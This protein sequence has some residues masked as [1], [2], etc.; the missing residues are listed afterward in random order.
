VGWSYRKSVRMGPLRVNFSRSGASV[1]TGIKGARVR[2]GPRGTYVTFSA[3]GFRYSRKLAHSELP[4]SLPDGTVDDLGSR[5]ATASVS[6]LQSISAEEN[7][8]ELQS[9]I[10]SGG[11]AA[12]WGCFSVFAV[13]MVM[14]FVSSD[15]LVL[16]TLIAVSFLGLWVAQ[17]QDEANAPYLFYDVDDSVVVERFARVSAAGEA[18]KTSQHLWHI[19]ASQ[20]TDDRK[21]NAGASHLIRRTPISCT[22]GTLGQLRMNIE[23]WSVPVGPQRLLFLPDRLLILEGKQLAGVP[24]ESL[25]L[26]CFPKNFIEEE[27]VPQDSR[28]VGTTWKYVNKNGS[29][30]RRFNNN[31]QLPIMEYGQLEIRTTSGIH[32]VLQ[33]SSLASAQKTA[34]ALASLQDFLR[35]ESSQPA[36]SPEQSEPQVEPLVA[37]LKYVALADR[38]FSSEE[39]ELIHE[40]LGRKYALSREAIDRMLDNPKVTYSSLHEA[41]LRQQPS[42]ARGEILQMLER[43]CAADGKV[44]P[45]ERERLA[46]LEAFLR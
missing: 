42:D 27:R 14:M 32:L 34:A 40:V 29:P 4:E 24:Y 20:Q 41:W 37:I 45:K 21:R 15:P 12:G 46:E 30:D 33:T 39:R 23:P 5:I 18:I 26:E 1:S 31:R 25:R 9:K 8:A 36:P 43:L 11:A 13:V 6:E 38:R 35:E 2:F 7:L 19:F 3:G 17:Q 28:Q 16:G 44:T 10:Q 22:P